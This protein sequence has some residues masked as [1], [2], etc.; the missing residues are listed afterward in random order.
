MYGWSAFEQKPAPS[1]DAGW[2]RARVN[3][4]QKMLWL[5]FAANKTAMP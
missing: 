5:G 1:L 3:K 2:I 4:T